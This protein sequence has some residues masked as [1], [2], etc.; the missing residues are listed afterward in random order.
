M[1][2]EVLKYLMLGLLVLTLGWPAY[3]WKRHVDARLAL[4]ERAVLYVF[5]PT[6]V[7]DAQGHALRRADLLDAMMAN[8]VKG[9]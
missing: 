4:S 8:A 1:V 7:K 6:E 5:A 9:K 3:Q 2:G